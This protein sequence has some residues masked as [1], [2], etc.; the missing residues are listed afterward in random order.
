MCDPR[1]WNARA[2]GKRREACAGEG[3]LPVQEP[4]KGPTSVALCNI[5]GFTAHATTTCVWWKRYT[6]ATT[7]GFPGFQ[8]SDECKISEAT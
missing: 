5:E 6:N 7:A 1:S 3:K 4:R 8:T 2:I